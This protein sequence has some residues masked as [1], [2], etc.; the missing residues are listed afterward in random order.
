MKFLHT[1]FFRLL[2]A[3]LPNRVIDRHRT[4]SGISDLRTAS[5]DR[6]SSQA[7]AYSQRT[8]MTSG[9]QKSTSSQDLDDFEDIISNPVDTLHITAEEEKKIQGIL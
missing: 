3:I 2:S 4:A 8:Q 6:V 5:E 7:T 1:Y 9:T